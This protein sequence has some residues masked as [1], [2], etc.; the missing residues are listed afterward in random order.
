MKET[1]DQRKGNDHD[2]HSAQYSVARTA[3]SRSNGPGRRER[4]RAFVEVERALTDDPGCVFCH[5][6]CAALIV[7]ADGNAPR[8]ALAASIADRGDIPGLEQSR[9]SARNCRAFAIAR[10][11]DDVPR[12]LRSITPMT[13]GSARAPAAVAVFEF[14]L[15]MLHTTVVLAPPPSPTAQLAEGCQLGRDG[16]TGKLWR[17]SECYCVRAQTSSA[18][19]RAAPQ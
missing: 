17:F 9:T 18:S 8:S 7:R 5:C 16:P 6:L 4:G 19:M 2:Y 10:R 1:A 12:R 13:A 11:K 3:A 14:P 15:A